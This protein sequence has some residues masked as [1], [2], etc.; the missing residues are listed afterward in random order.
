M[1]YDYVYVY[2]GFVVE[3]YKLSKLTIFSSC[4]LR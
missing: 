2:A 3:M 4:K 1:G